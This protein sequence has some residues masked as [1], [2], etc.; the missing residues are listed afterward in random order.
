MA[1]KKNDDDDDLQDDPSSGGSMPVNDAWTG[2]LAISLL[3]L[4]AGTGFL[5]WDYYQ[6]DDGKP[7]PT[8]PKLVSSPPGTPPPVAQPAPVQPKVDPPKGDPP[9]KVDP[10]KGDPPAGP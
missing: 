4:M 8:V 2:L 1:K 7:L 5:A 6:Y 3:A 9:P 10:P